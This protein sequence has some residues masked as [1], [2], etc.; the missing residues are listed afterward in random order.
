[1]KPKPGRKHVLSASAAEGALAMLLDEQHG[2]AYQVAQQLQLQG[3][4]TVIIH[5][6]TVVRAARRAAMSAGKSLRAV[7]GTPTKRL[8]DATKAKRRTFSGV[9]MGRA[10]GNVMFTDRKR[11]LFRYPGTR[12][13]PVKWV[14]Q[15]EEHMAVAVN[16]PQCLNVYAGITKHGVTKMHIVAGSSKHKTTFKNKGGDPAKNITAAEYQHVLNTTLL[17]EGR[18]IFSTQ[19]I[20]SWV[21]QQD[22]DPSHKE[23]PKHVQQWNT[24]NS[25]SV[26]VLADWPPNS[27][28]LNPIENVW[29]YVQSKV[30]QR[31]CKTFEEFKQAVLDE[32]QAVPLSMLRNLFDSMPRRVAR[33]TQLG[34]DKSGY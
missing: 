14:L 22:N 11:F 1:M 2:T 12:V 10:W 6:T 26:S 21:L 8:T 25:S 31:G 4:T 7:R 15:G 28:D 18:R 16:H 32:F 27:P 20:S 34:G 24:Q 3:H 33:V 13:R 23:A 19:G 29:A 9:N 5:R 30:D 17:P